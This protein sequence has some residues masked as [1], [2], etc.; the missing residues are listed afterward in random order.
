MSDPIKLLNT[1]YSN[2]KLRN[3]Y[4][5]CSELLANY[6]EASLDTKKEYFQNCVQKGTKLVFKTKSS[7]NDQYDI[8][9][10]EIMKRLQQS[11]IEIEKF[12]NLVEEKQQAIDEIKSKNN[13]LESKNSE[14]LLI[15]MY[16]S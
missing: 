9:I 12:T 4:M 14:V 6:S 2:Q 8:Q 10:N 16:T 1:Y 15:L 3:V 13:D 11:A 7:N 5:T